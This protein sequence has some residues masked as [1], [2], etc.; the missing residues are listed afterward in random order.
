MIYGTPILYEDTKKTFAYDEKPEDIDV[1]KE[2]AKL[3][4][5]RRDKDEADAQDKLNGMKK[6]YGTAKSTLVMLYNGTGDTL[7]LRDADNQSGHIW[8]YDYDRR[9][10]TG[11]WSVFLHV[12]SQGSG[13]GSCA[14]VAYDLATYRD[15]VDKGANHPLALL[16]AWTTPWETTNHR[17]RGYAAFIQQSFREH[18][19]WGYWHQKSDGGKPLASRDRGSL[20]AFHSV[21]QVSSPIHTYIAT[22]SDIGYLD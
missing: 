12:H 13:A 9:I 19:G 2:M 6:E 11:Q 4:M 1:R 8:K 17:N 7:K 10:E 22:R 16:I 15:E 21:T 3:A 20:R 14:A 18:K 5:E